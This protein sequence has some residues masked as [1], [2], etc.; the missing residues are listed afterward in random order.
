MLGSWLARHQTWILLPTC[1]L[2]LASFLTSQPPLARNLPPFLTKIKTYSSSAYS[3][4]L[5][6]H[7]LNPAQPF[8]KM[9]KA[10]VYFF[11]HGGA[12]LP[13]PTTHPSPC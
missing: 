12:S 8:P 2:I 1:I 7:N 3:S 9:P 4:L 10:P 13:L 5:K 6:T 11:S